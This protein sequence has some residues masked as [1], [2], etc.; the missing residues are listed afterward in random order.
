MH[1]LHLSYMFEIITG[2]CVSDICVRVKTELTIEG[3]VHSW[4]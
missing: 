2:A 1:G 3:S 4:M